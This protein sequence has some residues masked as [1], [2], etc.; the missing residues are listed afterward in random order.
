MVVTIRTRWTLDAADWLPLVL[1]LPSDVRLSDDQL[2]ELCAINGELRIERS[3]EGELLIMPPEGSGTGHSNAT[4]T[5][6]VVTWAE[7][8]GTGLAFGSAAGF[9][10]PNGAMRSPDAA[11]I[12]RERWERLTRD[13]QRKFAPIC[14]DFVLELRSP[15]DRLRDLQ[16]K[17]EE[18]IANGAR[19]GWLLDP[20]RRQAYVYR[21]GA[22]VERLE[23][24]T[25]IAGD[26]VLPGLVLKP[27]EIW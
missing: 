5:A 20:E 16:A 12:A 4:I 11:W 18:Y 8:D 1:R 27:G 22:P 13:E 10:L 9:T 24:P 25:E 6:R 21:P 23:D 14:P 15:S 17:M 2:L 19:L 7:R 3:A 26:P